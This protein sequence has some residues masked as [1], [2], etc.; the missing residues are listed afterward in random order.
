LEEYGFS[1]NDL[2]LVHYEKN[3]IT[4]KKVTGR[5]LFQR[6]VLKNPNLQAF[7]DAFDLEVVGAS[8]SK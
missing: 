4:I 5:E 1:T 6:M 7:A 3:K 2:V 8:I